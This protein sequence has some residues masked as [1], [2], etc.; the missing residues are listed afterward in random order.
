MQPE[1]IVRTPKKQ[2]EACIL[3]ELPDGFEFV[4]RIVSNRVSSIDHLMGYLQSD[5]AFMPSPDNIKDMDKAAV[6]LAETIRKDEKI[7]LHYDWDSDGIGSAAL[8][9]RAFHIFGYRKFKATCPDRATENHG[10]N[11]RV[12]D[13]AEAF[14]ASLILTVDNGSSNIAEIA[15]AKKRGMKVIITDHH[16][17]PD[18]AH[19]ADVLVNPKHPDDTSG[20]PDFCGAGIAYLLML[21]LA[22]ILGIEE[23]LDECLQMAA[24]STMADVVPLSVNNRRL[25]KAGVEA[26]RA[27]PLPLVAAIAKEK[28]M[29]TATIKGSDLAWSYA[30]LVN[31]AG[32]IEKAAIAYAALLAQEGRAEKAAAYL[33]DCNKRR[34]DMTTRTDEADAEWKYEGDSVVLYACKAWHPGIVGLVAGRISRETGKVAGCAMQ[35]VNGNWRFSLR[36][37]A[38]GSGIAEAIKEIVSKDL[39]LGGG[40][41]DGAG[42][43]TVQPDKLDL[44]ANAFDKAIH[45]VVVKMEVDGEITPSWWTVERIEFMDEMVEPYGHANPAVLMKWQGVID[46]VSPIGEQHIKMSADG[47]EAM[48]FNVKDRDAWMDAVRGRSVTIVYQPSVNK[49]RGTSRVQALV[50]M[51]SYEQVR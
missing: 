36:S 48:W 15:E 17:T 4:S 23:S 43:L 18:A 22:E 29:E 26:I 2:I 39:S 10:L 19:G 8:V 25:V 30:P 3:P 20:D 37:P 50:S 47:I 13:E 49:F 35:D 9:T 24:I 31:A 6:L 38:T 12:I 32:R 33:L 42:G 41:H 34:R 40:G 11:M 16:E 21:K 14:G 28:K 44:F 7:C 51:V 5:S 1:I 27:N 45:N 46:E